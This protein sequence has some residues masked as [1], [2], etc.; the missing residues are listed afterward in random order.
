[1]PFFKKNNCQIT[2]QELTSIFRF[3][4]YCLTCNASSSFA[5]FLHWAACTNLDIFKHWTKRNRKNW[6]V[7]YF[8]SRLL[9]KT[10]ASR[11]RCLSPKLSTAVASLTDATENEYVSPVRYLSHVFCL[12][13]S[14]HVTKTLRRADAAWVEHVYI[15]EQNWLWRSVK[16]NSTSE[17]KHFLKLGYFYNKRQLQFIFV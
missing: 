11:M 10:V 17:R 15:K 4:R 9:T 6:T 2:N 12:I 5:V 14:V 13:S 1:V 3:F 8:S 7:F 16:L